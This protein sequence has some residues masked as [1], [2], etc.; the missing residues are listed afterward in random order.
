MI[1]LGSTVISFRIIF[2]L[3]DLYNPV[4][5]IDI[6]AHK[7]CRVFM[8]ISGMNKMSYIQR[9]AGRKGVTEITIIGEP[10][11]VPF[12]IRSGNDGNRVSFPSFLPSYLPMPLRLSAPRACGIDRR[13][14][15]VDRAKGRSSACSCFLFITRDIF[16]ICAITGSG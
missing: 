5:S 2:L 14:T 7:A 4:D 16:I 15:L 13:L 11:R 12:G 10:A 1:L 3:C 8:M 9:P 6:L